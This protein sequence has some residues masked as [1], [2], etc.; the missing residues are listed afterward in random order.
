MDFL[1]TQLWIAAQDTDDS[2]F[3]QIHN[4]AKIILGSL[5]GGAKAAISIFSLLGVA[6]IVVLVVVV[7]KKKN[8]PSFH[9]L[10]VK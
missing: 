5:S 6:I 2:I 7:A 3:F 4:P 10:R 8:Y 1:V 9:W